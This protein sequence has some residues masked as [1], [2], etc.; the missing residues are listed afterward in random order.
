MVVGDVYVFEDDPSEGL[1]ITA[2]IEGLRVSLLISPLFPVS[3]PGNTFD[4]SKGTIW[5]SLGIE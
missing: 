5:W 1:K 2:V 4:P 3:V